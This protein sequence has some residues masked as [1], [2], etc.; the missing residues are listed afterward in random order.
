M[1]I[2]ISHEV[3]HLSVFEYYKDL[4]IPKYIGLNSIE[5]CKRKI[6]INTFSKETKRNYI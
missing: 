1:R 2:I 5:L 6:S 4:I 3:D